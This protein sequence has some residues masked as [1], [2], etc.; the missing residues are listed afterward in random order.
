MIVRGKKG[1]DAAPSPSCQLFR[2]GPRQRQ[3]VERA[4]AASDL[5]KD[6]EA[7]FGGLPQDA[8][9]LHH[10]HHKRT[11]AL[12]QIVRS[13]Y[14]GEDA[15][16]QAKLGFPGRDE[17][18]HLREEA[19]QCGLAEYGRLT[20]HVGAGD[21]QEPPVLIHMEVVGHERGFSDNT[22]NDWVAPFPDCDGLPG[23][24]HGARPVVAHR[25][26]RQ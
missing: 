7:A 24:K 22:L 9:G 13:A 19:D 25:R 14:A 3:P 2:Y 6:D 10:F 12:R 5:V 26:F 18:T 4:R 1:S 17:R 23:M 21:Q 8:C 20:R 11:L 15:I 16:A